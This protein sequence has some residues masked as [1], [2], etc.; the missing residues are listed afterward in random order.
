MSAHRSAFC[1]I[2]GAAL[3]TLPGVALRLPGIHAGPPVTALL[4]GIAI[5]GAA[6]L[7][8]WA[9]DAAQADI[10]QALALAVVALIAV[11][12]EYAVDMYFTWMA[13]SQDSPEYAH[14]AI[15]NMTGANRLLI[16]VAWGVI[17]VIFWFKTR[18]A[19]P[20]EEDRRL[21]LFFLA[22]ATIYAFLI[23]IKGSL[24]WMD[25]VVFLGIYVWYIALASKRPVGEAEADGPAC[26]LLA[27]PK[28]RRIISTI[29]LFLF[30]GTVIA[31]C[32]EP[33]S[34]GLVHTGKMFHINEFLL[35][36][37]LAPLAS[38]SPEFIIAALFALRGHAGLAL[39]SLLSS[40]LNQ[41]T[42]LVGMIPG[43]YG[44]ARGSF[45]RPIPMNA[46]QMHE[47]LLTAAQSLL[48]VV[49]MARLRL[50][51]GNA[52]LLFVLFIGQ[53]IAPEII[54]HMPGGH[55]GM[56]SPDMV[57]PLFCTLYFAC[58]FALICDYPKRVTDLLQGRKAGQFTGTE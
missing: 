42:L 5:M 7:L 22:A 9:C 51:L 12:P 17:A 47:I 30:A 46:F 3:I 20:L 15:A 52:A 13:G 11:L 19:V 37:W 6:F 23:P 48:A 34:E 43:V 4:T 29:G 31:L 28:R 50:S 38:E 32:A 16:G 44:V 27:M 21:E 57:H 36:Q 8:T 45:D 1:A 26:L 55:M 14:Y 24:T 49:I 10:S 39:G 35:V 54:R 53:F 40:K 58:A 25:G 41:W 56:V 33:F 18:R 2:A